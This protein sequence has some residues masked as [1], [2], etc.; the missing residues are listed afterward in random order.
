ML[1]SLMP[2]LRIHTFNNDNISP[3][4]GLG[5]NPTLLWLLSFFAL[6]MGFGVGFSG[7]YFDNIPKYIPVIIITLA[8]LSSLIPIF[9]DKINKYLSYDIRSSKGDWA[10]KKLIVL[11]ISIQL[12]FFLYFSLFAI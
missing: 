3:E 1:P 4:T 8:L 6:V 10:L 11:A 7:L 9:P 2:L 5:Y 12:I